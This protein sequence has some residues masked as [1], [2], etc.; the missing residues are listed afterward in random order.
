VGS[1]LAYW[2][3]GLYWRPVKPLPQAEIRQL[4]LDRWLPAGVS[5]PEE[6]L[7][8]QEV[9]AAIIRVTSGNFRLLDRL[10]TQIARLLEINA[11]DRVTAPV[12]EAARESLVTA[13]R[14]SGE[15]Y[16]R[17]AH[18]EACYSAVAALATGRADLDAPRCHLSVFLFPD[19]IQL[20]RANITVPGKLAHLMHLGPVA[21]RI[22]DGSLA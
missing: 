21:D 3:T 22:V 9:M 8:D 14:N 19:E 18:A 16:A 13:L 10:L 1:V 6:T 5:L 4:L 20:R 7:V 15:P 11:M 12:V 17:F 2:A